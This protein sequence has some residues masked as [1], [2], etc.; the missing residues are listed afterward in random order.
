MIHSLKIQS[1]DDSFINDIYEKAMAELNEF[2]GINWTHHLPV[3][4]TVS[5]RKTIDAL[6]GKKTE[7]WL[8]GWADGNKIFVLDK[9]NFEKESNHKYMPETYHSLI[10][11]ELSHAFYRVLSGD[12]MRPI[13]LCEGVAIYTSGQNKEKSQPM[14]FK[15]FLD[16]QDKGGR[17]VYA[18]SGFIVELLVEKFGKSKLLK[19][20]DSTKTVDDRKG[21]EKAFKDVYGFDPTYAE[22]NERYKN[23]NESGI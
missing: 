6:K 16:F 17:G 20:I 13:W 15:E 2:Y 1:T 22:F 8:V 19:L 3:V 12:R 23:S 11:H 14:E 7:P 9:E 4:I 5:D 10:K 18:E 21:F